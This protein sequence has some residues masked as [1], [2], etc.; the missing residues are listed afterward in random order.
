MSTPAEDP[1]IVIDLFAE[2]ASVLEAIGVMHRAFDEYTAKGQ[3]SG[4]LQETADTLRA[5]MADGLRLGV[6]RAGGRM[7]AVVKYTRAQDGTLYF[8][9]LGVDPDARGTGLAGKLVRA[10]RGQAEAEGL[11]GLSCAVRADEAG[12]IALYE[13][14]GM[15]IVSRES[16]VSRTG[17][18]LPVVVMKDRVSPAS[19]R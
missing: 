6:V 8:G 14:L 16:R 13:Y 17:A 10:L 15:D 1:R 2:E 18:V 3:P 9:R 11:D 19:A 12:N 5:E 4:A 7:V